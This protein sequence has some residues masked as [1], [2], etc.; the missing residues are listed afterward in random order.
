MAHMI[1]DND[2]ISSDE[3]NDADAEKYETLRLKRIR[4]NSQ[5]LARDNSQSSSSV[6]PI[7]KAAAM[8]QAQGKALLPAPVQAAVDTRV[9]GDT[10]DEDWESE[11]EPDEEGSSDARRRKTYTYLTK[12]NGRKQTNAE[13]ED[14]DDSYEFPTAM[15]RK[16]LQVSFDREVVHQVELSDF[17]VRSFFRVILP[18][19]PHPNRRPSK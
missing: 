17:R 7:E 2:D 8:Q 13:D 19:Q 10:D 5:Q 16:S 6:S 14:S 1:M 3:E 15:V 9:N 11:A 18:T 4:R 12:T